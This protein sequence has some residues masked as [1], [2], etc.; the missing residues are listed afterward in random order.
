MFENGHSSK[1][2]GQLFVSSTENLGTPG[3]I[4]KR[5]EK[6]KLFETDPFCIPVAMYFGGSSNRHGLH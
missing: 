5:K 3:C 4:L 6:S 1:V 2:F